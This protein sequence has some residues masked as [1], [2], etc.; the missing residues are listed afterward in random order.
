MIAQSHEIKSLEQYWRTHPRWKG[1]A[2]PYRAED[3]SAYVALQEAEFAAERRGYTASQHQREVGVGYFDDVTRVITQGA[4]S[5]TAF[6]GST[7]EEQFHPAYGPVV[8][9][10]AS[11][12][13][14]EAA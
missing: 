11:R 8:Q 4:S 14:P 9:P 13:V 1:I 7:E 3:M 5:L 10:G 12:D 2:R 6:A